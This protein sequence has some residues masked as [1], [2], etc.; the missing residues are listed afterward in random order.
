MRGTGRA[1]QVLGI[2]VGEHRLSVAQLTLGNGSPAAIAPP[3]EF[4]YPP[5]LSLEHPQSLGAALREF[6]AQQGWPGPRVVLGVAAKWL[7]C[8]GVAIPPAEDS[9]ARQLLWVQASAQVPADLG[10]FS[11]DYLGD[12]DP[13]EPR[14]LLLLGL[15]RRWRDRLVAMAQSAGL[16]VMAIR[17]TPATLARAAT[18]HSDRSLVV[19][20]AAEGFDVLI[21]QHRRTASLRHVGPISAV[22][23]LA[24]QLRRMLA[25]PAAVAGPQPGQPSPP[26]RAWDRLIVWDEVGLPTAVWTA[27]ESAAAELPVV[28]GQLSWLGQDF[29]QPSAANA[30]ATGSGGSE[31]ASGTSSTSLAL[32]AGAAAVALALSARPGSGNGAD[33][34]H[35][36]LAPPVEHHV[37]RRT[38]WLSAAV[39]A[40]VI[41]AVAIGATIDLAVVGR[42]VSQADAQLQSLQPALAVARPAVARL[43]LASSFQ[44]GSEWFLACLGDLA[45]AVP[46]DGRTYLTSFNLNAEMAGSAAGRATSQQ[47]VLSLLDKLRAARRFGRI[48]CK[49]DEH[50]SRRRSAAPAPADGNGG[51]PGGSGAPAGGAAPPAADVTFSISFSYLPRT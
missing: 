40:G 35:P 34:L 11:F 3:A 22:Q 20:A 50:P 14:E 38:L 23:P 51:A 46:E 45:L 28:R 19:C 37:P 48:K 16:K 27:I 8:K 9:T 30:A 33:F 4:V 31:A 7:I 32:A 21:Q 13:S 25:A 1:R 29:L 49:L 42:Q 10:P 18:P 36:R 12:A 26:Q 17:P 44:T 5:D 24:A 15:G 43:Q 47:D 6:L 2:A 39:A 41:A